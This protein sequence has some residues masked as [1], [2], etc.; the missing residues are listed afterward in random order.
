MRDGAV[1]V[2]ANAAG[3]CGIGLCLEELDFLARHF[4]DKSQCCEVESS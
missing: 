3:V 2:W 1:L 4:N